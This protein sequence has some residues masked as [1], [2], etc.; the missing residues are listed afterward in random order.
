M[1]MKIVSSLLAACVALAG[2]AA[3]AHAGQEP[4]VVR[5]ST[6]YSCGASNKGE[7]AFLLYSSDCRE[8][9]V[10]NGA[11][12]LTCTHAVFAQ[13]T[14][15]PGEAKHFPDIPPGIKQCQAKNGRLVFPDCMR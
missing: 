5:T 2:A 1:T 8:G 13:F 11:P 14:L 9:E 4:R 15:K 12:S 3:F 6:T 7:C 10:R